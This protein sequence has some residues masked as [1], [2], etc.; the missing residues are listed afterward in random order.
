MGTSV[1][2][3]LDLTA[4]RV[5]NIGSLRGFRQSRYAS[6]RQVTGTGISRQFLE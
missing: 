5:F 2:N 6:V 3:A 1:W 4:V